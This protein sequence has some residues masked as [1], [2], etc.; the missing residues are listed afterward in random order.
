MPYYAVSSGNI[1]RCVLADDPTTAAVSA[2]TL[3]IT[4]EFSD[5]CHPGQV[6]EVAEFGQSEAEN[7]IVATI[8]VLE[9]GGFEVSQ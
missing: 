4:D 3:H 7:T 6:V 5:D 1:F 2:F 9:I 8:R